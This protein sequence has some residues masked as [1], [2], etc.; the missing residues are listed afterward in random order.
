[1]PEE[2]FPPR[3]VDTDSRSERFSRKSKPRKKNYS[4]TVLAVVAWIFGFVL[5]GNYT[6]TS[7][8]HDEVSAIKTA[9]VQAANQETFRRSRAKAEA[10]F[11]MATAATLIYFVFAVG[12]TIGAAVE[13]QS[14]AKIRTSD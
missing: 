7:L 3:I 12:V 5:I 14:N 1:M 10:K 8:K 4:W 9:D 13:Q 2:T 11:D 6:L